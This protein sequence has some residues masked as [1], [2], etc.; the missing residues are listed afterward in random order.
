[1]D[2]KWEIRTSKSYAIETR[3]DTKKTKQALRTAEVNILRQILGKT[4]KDRIRNVN[5][6]KEC[7]IQD[8]SEEEIRMNTYPEW[9]L[10]EW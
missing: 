3:A 5:I 1:M 7:D 4:R 9:M 6:R 10:I 2:T 8:E